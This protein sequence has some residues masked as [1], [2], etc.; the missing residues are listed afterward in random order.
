MLT[1]N[2]TTAVERQFLLERVDE[3]AVVQIYADGFQN[4][5][6]REKVL[7]WHLSQAAKAGRD[8][9]YDQKYAPSL[10]MRVLRLEPCPCSAAHVT[11][12]DALRVKDAGYLTRSPRRRGG[13]SRAAR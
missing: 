5:S 3:A 11:G 6:L 8:I 7:V 4:L 9:F 10:E 12:A 13:V 1:S 2:E